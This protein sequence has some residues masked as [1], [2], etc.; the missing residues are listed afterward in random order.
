MKKTGFWYLARLT[1]EAYEDMGRKDMPISPLQKSIHVAEH[2]TKLWHYTNIE[3]LFKILATETFR[4]SRIDCVN[5]LMEKERIS[6]YDLY[7]KVF[8]ACF[9]N[10]ETESIPL[11]HMYTNKNNGVRIG[12]EFKHS[13]INNIMF[14]KSMS[15]DEKKYSCIICDVIYEDNDVH[16]PIMESENDET[17]IFVDELAAY[18]TKMWEYEDETRIILF[19]E[20]V[21]NNNQKYVNLPINYDEISKIR[22]M[23]NPWMS[24]EIKK[25]V[26][27]T[28]NYYAKEHIKLFE[29]IDS[30]LQGKI[31]RK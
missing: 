7:K 3:S 2:R 6:S 24:E 30:D 11:W 10:N 22:V 20:D 9:S 5:D 14:R 27:L 21:S 29:F 28:V 23:F 15:C 1:D 25:S 12:I 31:D 8:V 17:S 26:V 19:F 18:K 4:F 13:K 16:C